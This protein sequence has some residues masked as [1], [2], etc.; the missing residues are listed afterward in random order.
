MQRLNRLLL[1]LVRTPENSVIVE[2]QFA[3]LDAVCMARPAG[4]HFRGFVGKAI[5]DLSILSNTRGG[6][7][8][9]APQTKPRGKYEVS[10][11][12]FRTTAKHCSRPVLR[13]W[14]RSR[15]GIAPVSFYAVGWVVSA[16]NDESRQEL[17]VVPM[18]HS[19]T[20]P[21]NCIS[22]RRMIRICGSI[23]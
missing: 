6:S 12:I 22:S 18:V 13:D 7:K 14:A 2:A 9:S 21:E 4:P 10:W 23:L 15:F 17:A 1:P 8:A 11:M 20:L 19:V 3:L 16:A 5:S